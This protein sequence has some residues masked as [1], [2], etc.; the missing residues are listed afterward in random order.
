MPQ[1]LDGSLENWEDLARDFRE[2]ALLLG[3]GL[4][5]NV[6][7][8]FAYRAL[9]D[10]AQSYGLSRVD[11]ELFG[12]TSNFERVL[13]DLGTAIR[14]DEILGLDASTAQQRYRHIQRALGAAIREVHL[15]RSRVPD[16]T[17]EAIREEIAGYEWVFTTCYD[18]L[19]YWAMGYGGVWRPFVDGFKFGGRLEFDPTRADVWVDEVPVYYL[20]GALHLVV[21]GSG[22]TWKLRRSAI[23][24]IL[25]QFGEPI[26]ADPAAR[27]LLVTEG[28]AREKLRAIEGNDYLAHALDRLRAV[29]LPVVVFGSSLSDQDHHLVDALNEHTGRAI[30]VSMMTGAKREVAG[31]QAEIY[32]R[33][34]TDRL[35]FFDAATHP[36]GSPDLRAP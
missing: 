24:T 30:A 33:L 25:D 14:V 9:F 17:L 36:L 3:N 6:W 27:P 34:Q 21:G 13:A 32:G 23:Q 4:S 20:H 18:L 15:P 22:V 16:G 7:P 2:S 11:L 28:S 8:R 19:L 1:P 35:V 29:E 26:A 5:I 10:H 31:R 12:G